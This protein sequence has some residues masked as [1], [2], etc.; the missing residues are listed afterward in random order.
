[1]NILMLNK[2]ALDLVARDY[3]K[4]D[5]RDPVNA[6]PTKTSRA[7]AIIHLAA[8]DAYAAVTK[9]YAP[10]LAAMPALPLGFVPAT[11]IA[12]ALSAGFSAAEALYPDDA[13]YIRDQSTNF[14]MGADGAEIDYGFRVAKAWMDNRFK[15]GAELPQLDR[16]Y[17]NAPGAHRPDPLDPMQQTLGRTWGDVKPFVITSVATCAPLGP[18]PPLGGNTYVD[19][20]ND[21]YKHGKSSNPMASAAFRKDAI[22][23]IFWGYDGSNKLGTPPRLYNQVVVATPAFQG[24]NASEQ[25]N[26][27]AAINAAMADAGIAAW[28]WKYTYDRWRPVVGIRESSL[29]WGTTGTGDSSGNTHPDPFW[30]PLGAPASNQNIKP[31]GT[32]GF[33]AY[34]SGHSTF[35]SACFQTFACMIEKSTDDIALDFVSDEFNGITT[36]NHGATR[37]RFVDRGMTLTRAIA[38]NSESR[39]YLGVHWKSDA[40]GGAEVGYAI[41]DKCVKAFKPGA[42]DCKPVAMPSKKKKKH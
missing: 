4:I 12:A 10:H 24:L 29:G 28:Y 35:G 11:G 8:R 14:L 16:I 26:V 40:T 30:L 38:D 22:K 25:I 19:E 36:D 5:G 3:S 20:F 15:D 27:L 42:P 41:A 7:L 9:H 1:M 17:S 37:P 2:L 23:G 18:P 13:T 31:N 6:G 34:P 32:P 33:P 39:I 21:V